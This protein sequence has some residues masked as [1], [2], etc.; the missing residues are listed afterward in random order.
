MSKWNS[1]LSEKE[2]IENKIADIR[3]YI[4]EKFPDNITEMMGCP[5]SVLCYLEDF[6]NGCI[7]KNKKLEQQNKMMR[8]CLETIAEQD[9]SVCVDARILLN[10]L[11]ESEK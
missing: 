11:K 4:W 6:L 7:S 8:E 1:N 5:Y 3:G 2:N 9:H 10:K